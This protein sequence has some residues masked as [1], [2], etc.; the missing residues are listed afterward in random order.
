MKGKVL[1]DFNIALTVMA[2]EESEDMHL[3]KCFL[4]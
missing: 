2:L 1:V 4:S 3:L